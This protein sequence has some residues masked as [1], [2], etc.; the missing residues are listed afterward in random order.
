[1]SNITLR[2]K[3]PLVHSVF[4]ARKFPVHNRP[5]SLITREH[6]VFFLFSIIRVIP[7]ISVV[8]FSDISLCWPQKSE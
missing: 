7:F 4:H 2:V 6:L 8:L 5:H 3:L 1:M